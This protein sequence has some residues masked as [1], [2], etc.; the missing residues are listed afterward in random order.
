[1]LAYAP[2]VGIVV[3]L[4]ELLLVPRKEVKVRFHAA[5][6]FALHIAFLAIS[7]IFKIVSIVGAGDFGQVLFNLASTIFLVISMIRVWRGQPH[8]IAPLAEPTKW[9]N[10]RIE[11]HRQ[12]QP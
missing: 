7:T 10:E 11:A 4:L 1:M 2:Y 5:Q 8:T 9:L 12:S 3:S 6:A